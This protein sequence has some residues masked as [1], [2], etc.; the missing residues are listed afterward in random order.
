MQ[1]SSRLAHLLGEM[2]RQMNGAVVGSMRFYGA[3]YG[4]NYGVS[5]PTIRQ[6][7]QC[8]KAEVVEQD[9]NHRFARQLMRQEVRE[10]RLAA[11]W[12]AAPSMVESLD[13]WAPY[14]INSEV[15]EEAAFALFHNVKGIKQW[16]SADRSELLHYCAMLSEAKRYESIEID[17]ES[18]NTLWDNILRLINSDT[19]LLPKGVVAFVDTLLKRGVAPEFI[20]QLLAKLPTDNTA[21]NYIRDEIAWRI[22]LAS[23]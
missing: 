13:E 22:D 7:A 20:E 8:E 17:S 16:L 3:D 12:F 9:V 2:R 6:V 1:H 4:L 14:I 21:S 5:I 23:C 15:A 11:F 19:A 10:L 18:I